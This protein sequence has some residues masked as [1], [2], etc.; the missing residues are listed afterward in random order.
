MNGARCDLY[1]LSQP[2]QLA[3]SVLWHCSCTLHSMVWRFSAA[4]PSLSLSVSA[5][6][7]LQQ[8]HL[9][10]CSFIYSSKVYQHQPPLHFIGLVWRMRLNPI[11]YTFNLLD[12]KTHQPIYRKIRRHNSQGMNKSKTLL[13]NWASKYWQNFLSCKIYG[14]I[15]F[16][17]FRK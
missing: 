16:S 17:L 1:C 3:A 5:M 4:P 9:S 14:G 2:Q 7:F 8:V 10:L 15:V 6:S 13:F 11:K 12:R